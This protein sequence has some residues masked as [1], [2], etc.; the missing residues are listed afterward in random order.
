MSSA[1]NHPPTVST[2]GRDALE[3]LPD[4]PRLP[5]LVVGGVFE[6]A[7]VVGVVQHAVALGAGPERAHLQ[8]ELVAAG[9]A[10]VEGHPR[11]RP[12]GLGPHREARVEAEV[13]GQHERAVVER[14]VAQ[15]VVGDRRLRRHRLQRRMRVDHA[16]RDVEARIR[17]A[18]HADA[19]RCCRA[20]SSPA[21]R[22]CPRCRCSR[23]CPSTPSSGCAD[24]PP[25]TRPRRDS[26]RARPGRPRSRLP[27][28]SDRTAR[29]WCGSCRCRTAP[30]N[31]ACAA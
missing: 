4:R 30:P 21:S 1:S 11:L 18:P 27:S 9:R 5:E 17:D 22:W 25:P 15:V 29:S 28:G 31:T 26:G 8:E 19:R 20:R 3:V 12:L 14:V 6:V 7:A 16:G 10:V 2:A 24:A 13:G 23:R